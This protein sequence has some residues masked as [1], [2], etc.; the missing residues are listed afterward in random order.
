MRCGG[1]GLTAYPL[2]ARIGA[3]GFLSP[4]AT[5]LACLAA[6]SWSFD[7]ASD[8]LEEIAGLRIDDETPEVVAHGNVIANNAGAGVDLVVARGLE[9]TNNQIVGN[10]AAPFAVRTPADS[11]VFAPRNTVLPS[12]RGW[13]VLRGEEEESGAPPRPV[14]P[15][16]LPPAPAP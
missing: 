10:T 1:C 8:R 15:P 14:P 6:A 3:E 2:D 4:H 7:V 13:E 9:L 16:P 11:V 5:R 12:R